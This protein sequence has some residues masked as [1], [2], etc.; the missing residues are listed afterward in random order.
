MQLVARERILEYTAAYTGER[1][2]EGRPKVA[3]DLVERMK[4]VTTE[5]AWG[6]LH[7]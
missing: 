1:F 3:D 6:T 2:A 7:G 4:K 5:E